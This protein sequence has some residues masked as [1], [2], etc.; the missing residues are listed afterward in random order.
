M[1]PP[2]GFPVTLQGSSVPEPLGF[3]IASGLLASRNT[4]S[5]RQYVPGHHILWPSGLSLPPALPLGPKY[6]AEGAVGSEATV[7]V[8]SKE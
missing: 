4:E 3:L 7:W 1:W 5:R 8:N 6:E 2:Y